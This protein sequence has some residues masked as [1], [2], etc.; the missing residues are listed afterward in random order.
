MAANNATKKQQIYEQYMMIASKYYSEQPTFNI[1]TFATYMQGLYIEYASIQGYTKNEMNKQYYVMRRGNDPLA[2]WIDELSYENISTLFIN[3][4]DSIIDSNPYHNDIHSF[5]SSCK[6]N[7][8]ACDPDTNRPC[9]YCFR[10]NNAMKG[11]KMTNKFLNK[12]AQKYNATQLH[13]Y[14]TYK[15]YEKEGTIF[16]QKIVATDPYKKID[17]LFRPNLMVVYSTI[18]G[19]P[20]VTSTIGFMA[21]YNITYKKFYGY[22]IYT[23]AVFH[24]A[25]NT[26]RRIM[27]HITIDL[28]PVLSKEEDCYKLHWLLAIACP[29]Y[30]GSAG[31][32]KV[33]LNAAL[34]RIGLQPVK[35]TKEY[36]RKSDW[37]AILSPTFEEYYAKKDAMFK[38]ISQLG[39]YYKHSNKTLR[40]KYK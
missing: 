31:F 9:K 15:Q 25:P 19:K 34:L 18:N 12:E 27:E 23:L 1:S 29:F 6:K 14:S 11:L 37:V 20:E 13:G 7:N 30:K 36:E 26:S 32:A 33:V 17:E 40:K 3:Q 16:K 35:E 38:P 24:T 2:T 10:Y 5:A 39:G 22:S 21:R 28:W 4:L 8:V